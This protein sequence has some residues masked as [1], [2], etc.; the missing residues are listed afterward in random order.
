MLLLILVGIGSRESLE[1]R[2]MVIQSVVILG[3]VVGGVVAGRVGTVMVS[4]VYFNQ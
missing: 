3:V 2:W 4:C 1:W